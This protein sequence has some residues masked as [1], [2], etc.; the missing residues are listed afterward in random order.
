MTVVLLHLSV[1][2]LIPISVNES[3]VFSYLRMLMTVTESPD[4]LVLFQICMILH[5]KRIPTGSKNVA[6]TWPKRRRSIV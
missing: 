1:H 2:M 6:Q 4:I 3:Y 5:A